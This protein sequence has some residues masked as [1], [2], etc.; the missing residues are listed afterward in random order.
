MPTEEDFPQELSETD[1]LDEMEAPEL[2]AEFL[3]SSL[4]KNREYESKPKFSP[5]PYWP[6]EQ[7]YR[8]LVR[9]ISEAAQK[10]IEQ[11]MTDGF[12]PS[13]MSAPIHVSDGY[14]VFIGSRRKETLNG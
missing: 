14:L 5:V 7:E 1:P 13:P 2:A 6:Q 3:R 8:V 9:P 10:E 4:K 12:L 11:L